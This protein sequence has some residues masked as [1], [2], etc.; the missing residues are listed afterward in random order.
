MSWFVGLGDV[1]HVEY[2]ANPRDLEKKTDPEKQ[3]GCNAGIAM[4]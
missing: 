2:M 3:V 1:Y 4:S